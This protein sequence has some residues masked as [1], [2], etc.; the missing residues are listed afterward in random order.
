[1]D[2]K[3]SV[4]NLVMLAGGAITL[5]ASFFGDFWDFGDQGGASAW[6]TDY[7]AFA[8]TIPAILAL[9]M[10]VWSL[11]E[12]AGV[13]LPAKVLTFD[14]TQLKATWGITAA[15]TM[16]AYLTVDGDK[17]LGFVVMFLGSAAMAGGAVMAL[18]GKGSEQVALGGAKPSAATAPAATVTSVATPP[19]PPP[20]TNGD[21]PVP[22]A[23]PVTPLPTAPPPQVTWTPVFEPLAP[24]T[25][26]P[27][28]PPTSG[29][30]PPPPPPPR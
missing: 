9:V 30:T 1:M 22:A 13:G 5:L 21:A 12:L 11:L 29:G 3:I 8:T 14:H 6:A 25:P 19:P 28:P 20:P 26:P 7:G 23:A 18:L 24:S 15:G 10:V 17:A 16:L 4:A 27:P 2:K